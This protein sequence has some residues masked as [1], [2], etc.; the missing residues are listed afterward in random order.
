MLLVLVI[1]LLLLLLV[2]WKF[3]NYAD[4]NTAPSTAYE[5]AYENVCSTYAYFHNPGNLV[6]LLLKLLVML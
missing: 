3:D 6:I 4:D 1:L 2:I 5:N